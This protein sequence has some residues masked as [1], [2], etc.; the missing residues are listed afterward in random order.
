MR[1]PRFGLVS[2]LLIGWIWMTVYVV[3][4]EV[5]LM[6]NIC[7]AIANVCFALAGTNRRRHR[8]Y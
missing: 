2:F 8:W 7:A 3:A 4:I 6:V 1:V 5:Y